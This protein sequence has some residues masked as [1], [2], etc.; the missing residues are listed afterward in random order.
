MSSRNIGWSTV[1]LRPWTQQDFICCCHPCFYINLNV[2]CELTDSNDFRDKQEIE[3]NG[4]AMGPLC[5]IYRITWY[6]RLLALSILTCS[7]N[8]SF[9]AL[10][11][12]DNSWSLENWSWGHR[13]PQP[14]LRNQFLH[15][16]QVRFD[17]LS[18]INFRDISGFPI[19][20][21]HNPY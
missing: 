17:L 2:V 3:I 9:L 12:S 7:P 15:R 5:T 4:G 16:V 11:A 1:P 19:L 21:A 20:G 18:S 6:L 8:M 10:L 13:P 14:P